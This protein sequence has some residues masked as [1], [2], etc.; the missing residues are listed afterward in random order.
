MARARRHCR[1]RR[2]ATLPLLDVSWPARSVLTLPIPAAT[3]A[4]APPGLADDD[5]VLNE[6]IETS[7]N[8]RW[9]KLT[10]KATG[11]S[12]A[13]SSAGRS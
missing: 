1:L 3:G 2:L 12:S 8:G 5:E 11:E 10:Q 7:K 9:Q 13:E 6:V 4:A